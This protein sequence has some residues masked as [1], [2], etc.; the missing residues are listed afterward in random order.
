MDQ[1]PHTKDSTPPSDKHELEA[2]EERETVPARLRRQHEAACVEV[3]VAELVAQMLSLGLRQSLGPAVLC[4][5][6][7]LLPELRTRRS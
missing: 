1:A 7:E 5:P 3:P 2:V 4:E 6:F